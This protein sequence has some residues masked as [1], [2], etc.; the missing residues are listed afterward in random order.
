MVKRRR[1]AGRWRC[2]RGTSPNQFENAF[3][4]DTFRA[5]ACSF[6]FVSTLSHLIHSFHPLRSERDRH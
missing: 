3:K 4:W 5:P 2:T 1:R 6:S